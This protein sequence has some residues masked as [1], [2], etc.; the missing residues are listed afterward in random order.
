MVGFAINYRARVMDRWTEVCRYDTCHGRLH[1][2]RFWLP[3]DRQIQEARSPIPVWDT[4]RALD[5]AAEDLERQWRTYRMRM[6]RTLARGGK[7]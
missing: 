6:R 2:H 1:M 7:R 3:P 4:K 5:A